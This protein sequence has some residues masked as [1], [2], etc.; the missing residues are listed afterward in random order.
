[1]NEA[2]EKFVIKNEAKK[3]SGGKPQ[4]AKPLARKN[5]EMKKSNEVTVQ[6]WLQ[7]EPITIPVEIN[8]WIILD[9]RLNGRNIFI[10]PQKNSI[11]LPFSACRV[12]GSSTK[13]KIKVFDLSKREN[14]SHC[15]PAT[16][17][18]TESIGSN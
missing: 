3:K 2:K 17:F 7:S 13:L 18:T 15:P 16:G 8:D 1:M 12:L 10:R 9:T 5:A 11:N 6:Y 14:H 4:T